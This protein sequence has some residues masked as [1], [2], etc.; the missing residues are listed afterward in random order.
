M[1]GQFLVRKQINDNQVKK[2]PV[3]AIRVTF[4]L[5]YSCEELEK[6]SDKS[7]LYYSR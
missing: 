6:T 4:T 2:Y 3:A 5:V 1:L 7:S